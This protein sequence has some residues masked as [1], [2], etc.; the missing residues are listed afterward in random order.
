M[1]HRAN[2]I[3]GRR[4]IAALSVTIVASS[5][6]LVPQAQVQAAA[7]ED[8]ANSGQTCQNIG[9]EYRRS[10]P[11]T[12]LQSSFKE[13]NED[14]TEA[15]FNGIFQAGVTPFDLY[16]GRMLIG[17]DPRIA[18]YV[19][20]IKVEGYGGEK[21]AT[22]RNLKGYALQ[23]KVTV[24]APNGK[25]FEK[26]VDLYV[27]PEN[28][29]GK[30]D[31]DPGNNPSI[32]A[33]QSAEGTVLARVGEFARVNPAPKDFGSYQLRVEGLPDG[34]TA[35]IDK[36][37]GEVKL[38]GTAAPRSAEIWSLP[39]LVLEK[40][41]ANN[42]G[43]L[44]QTWIGDA[45]NYY[46]PKITFSKPWPEI[47]KEVGIDQVNDPAMVTFTPLFKP[48]PGQNKG[49]VLM[50]RTTGKGGNVAFI[51]AEGMENQPGWDNLYQSITSFTDPD[52]M[53]SAVGDAGKTVK[54][55]S[56]VHITPFVSYNTAIGAKPYQ[57]V[58]S[59]PPKLAEHLT[60]ATVDKIGLGGDP[61]NVPITREKQPGSKWEPTLDVAAGELTMNL[62]NLQR[63]EG[64]RP[65][66]DAWSRS[67]SGS[68]PLA[69]TIQLTFDKPLEEIYSA[70][71][72]P[73]GSFRVD[74]P[75]S[76]NARSYKDPNNPKQVLNS[77]SSTYFT[78]ADSDGDGLSDAA[79]RDSRLGTDPC[80]ADTDGDGKND[81]AEVLESK[82]DPTIK[83]PVLQTFK[84]GLPAITQSSPQLEFNN[85]TRNNL[86]GRRLELQKNND[87]TWEKI[88]ESTVDENGNFKLDTSSLK[89]GDE[90]RV[91]VFTP[92]TDAQAG[93]ENPEIS[94]SITVGDGKDTEKTDVEYPGK[95]QVDAGENVTVNP[96]FVEE[97]TGEPKDKPEGATFSFDG[98]SLEKDLGDGVTATI[99][100]NSGEV[101]FTTDKGQATTGEKDVKVV[102]TYKDGSKDTATAYVKVVNTDPEGDLDGD[103]LPNEVDPDADGDGVNNA[104]EIEAGL[105][106]LNPDTN[107][108]GVSDGDE[109][110]DND[111]IE[112]SE[113]SEV[114]DGKSD[115]QLDGHDNLGAVDK[116]DNDGDGKADIVDAS[117]AST[118]Q[119][120]YKPS[121][122]K[123][124]TTIERNVDNRKQ[125]PETGKVDQGSFGGNSIPEGAH[126]TIGNQVDPRLHATLDD[127]NDKKTLTVKPD[128]DV[129]AGTY[130]VPV[131]VTYKD[132]STDTTTWEVTVEDGLANQS[133]L[134]LPKLVLF[135]GETKTSKGTEWDSVNDRPKNFPAAS[136]KKLLNENSKP[137]KEVENVNF[138]ATISGSNVTVTAKEGATPGTYRIP[139]YVSLGAFGDQGIRTDYVEVEILDPNKVDKD[140]LDGDKVPNDVDPDID[141]DGVNNAD[142][143]AIGTNPFNPDSDGDGV[144][145]GNEDADGDGLSNAQESDV[146]QDEDGTDKP[147]ADSQ[148]Y[149]D[150]TTGEKGKGGA[151]P[152][153]KEKGDPKKNDL[154]EA[155]TAPTLEPHYGPAGTVTAD[156][157]ITVNPPSF[158]TTDP[159]TGQENSG[160]GASPTAPEKT[161]YSIPQEVID[162]AKQDHG[163]TLSIDPD[164]GEITATGDQKVT[165]GELEVPVTVTYPDKTTDE[166][167]VA[168]PVKG[169]SSPEGTYAVSY[170]HQQTKAEQPTVVNPSFKKAPTDGSGA[171]TPVEG[172]PA[173]VEKFYFDKD[174]LRE[175]VTI[176]DSEENKDQPTALTLP[177]GGSAQ[178][179]P[180]TGAVTFTPGAST[181]AGNYGLP[182]VVDYNSGPNGSANA[183]FTVPKTSENTTPPAKTTDGTDLGY[184][185]APTV[186]PGGQEQQVSP[187]IN[188]KPVDEG[189]KIP[190]GTRFSF[191][192]DTSGSKTG[193]PDGVTVVAGEDETY[194][195]KVNLPGGGTAE[196]DPT[197]GV[198]T[199]KPNAQTTPTEQD[200]PLNLPVHAAYSTSDPA[201][202]DDVEIPVTIGKP[203]PGENPDTAVGA[204]LFY[205]DLPAEK[206]VVKDPNNLTEDEKTQIKNKLVKA[207]PGLDPKDISV[208]NNGT[209]TITQPGFE[210][211]TVTPDQVIEVENPDN[212]TYEVTYPTGKTGTPGSS[213][214]LPAKVTDANGAATDL[215]TGST[216]TVDPSD[217]PDGVTVDVDP[218]TGAVTVNLPDDAQPGDITFPITV[219]YPD[220]TKDT[221]TVTVHVQ[222][223]APAEDEGAVT[224]SYPSDK[225]VKP[226]EEVV[227]TPVVSGDDGLPVD[228][229]ADVEI[230]ADDSGLPDGS[231]VSVGDDGAISVE[232]PEGAQP[233]DYVVPVTVK[234]PDGSTKTTQVTVHVKDP[235]P[236]EDKGKDATKYDVV[237]PSGRSG[238]PDS[239]IQLP[240]EVTTADGAPTQLPVGTTITVAS[241]SD[242]DDLPPLPTGTTLDVDNNG[243][244]TVHL[245]KD[246]KPGFYGGEI[247]ITYPDGSSEKETFTIQV[248]D[249]TA[250][251]TPIGDVYDNVSLKPG[252]TETI[253]PKTDLP[254]GATVEAD[255]SNLPDGATVTVNPD[256]SL[257]VSLPETA[258]PGSYL[259][260][261]T[262]K[263]QNGKVIG[264]DII[265]V[266]VQDPNVGPGGSSDG[267][268]V[269]DAL[270]I[271][272]GVITA[273]A[274]INGIIN[275]LH[276]GDGAADSGAGQGGSGS[277]AGGSGTDGA[278]SAGTDAEGTDAEGT[279]AEGLE[280]T[281]D[282]GQSS[283]GDGTDSTTSDGDNS[284]SGLANTGAQ[285]IGVGLM[286]MLLAALG[287]VLAFFGIRRRKEES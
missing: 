228:L 221:P 36:N 143:V 52:D 128:P 268:S 149:T 17:V 190:D 287:S 42:G 245:P 198:V 102:I 202:S 60:G 98:G 150:P 97:N 126:Y 69:S 125:D 160:D 7:A 216:V 34:V 105:D 38:S 2:R 108:D 33:G 187:T 177:G 280:G 142:E 10:T 170:P 151:V 251:P 83:A 213:V 31:L 72:N 20:G 6:N 230:S 237:Y 247:T 49:D 138:T 19:T 44:S 207:N 104:D 29:P 234:Y 90:V 57:I 65:P 252:S 153:T 140:D 118:N 121:Q 92:E 109:D 209:V 248:V 240:P 8:Q 274:V 263:D 226:G 163:V 59:M 273:G 61:V 244:V 243:T 250:T 266:R 242:Q 201:D 88:S 51:G 75:F 258:A 32:R 236:A 48:L 15:K 227:F 63:G 269:D 25:T 183:Q 86:P 210:N 281:Q 284:T 76:L 78:F 238:T 174:K 278:D 249:T 206:V 73:D 164:T 77:F 23:P 186:V 139:V 9:G 24:S 157:T 12:R 47:S 166:T 67:L 120:V 223:P 4:A 64:L 168:I 14:L 217:L 116:T 132:G 81:G 54:I 260:P 80:V 46:R 141:G 106:P 181:P 66:L 103:G 279:D 22:Q 211:A 144:S 122:G 3:I 162:S 93:Y 239:N 110:T 246:A 169:E 85:V 259:V 56:A 233:G 178:I 271:G 176:A 257:T 147:S 148:D 129:P 16:G 133:E 285:V 191:N 208:S 235:A 70:N 137:V 193:L 58:L 283:Y 96:T 113:E 156:H 74:V 100:P 225:S 165:S 91:A 180:N 265:A 40:D 218:A 112:N 241:D 71:K 39:L 254:A 127:S 28:L 205:V 50:A 84:A 95:T 145:D 94:N 253:K 124:G 152:E 136:D 37:T 189:N 192:N 275:G 203:Q 261:V 172:V 200:K 197:T 155:A 159:A 188:G 179:D 43:F 231:Q 173:E 87:G 255:G 256:N 277:D 135:P 123:V 222:D 199:I 79:E 224:V 158:V 101:T 119:P 194:P 131:E 182:V 55:H 220:G 232:V 35:S 18:K 270:T 30:Y 1:K 212:S 114:P 282:E 146:P 167:T 276:A 214:K 134:K 13:W 111:G 130:T 161:T 62:Y 229:P 5:L 264:T 215:P 107:G 154:L 195:T 21:T 196:I 45:P 99:D 219:T 26:T 68:Y 286:G 89:S 184:E 11:S 171:L 272:A 115:G 267:L 262:V 53:E 204:P 41:A 27:Q 175:G 117:D 82:T 185:K